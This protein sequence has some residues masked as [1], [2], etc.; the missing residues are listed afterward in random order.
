MQ[1]AV[2]LSTD[3]VEPELRTDYWRDVTRPLF[4]TRPIAGSPQPALEGAFTTRMIGPMLVGRARF[5]AQA[6]VRDRRIVSHSGLEDFYLIQLFT[7]GTAAADCE[8]TRLSISA[9]DVYAFDMGRTFNTS[10]SAGSTL[11]V[12]LHRERLDRLAGGR[13]L[14]GTLFKSGQPLTRLLADFIVG[15]ND[16]APE[17]Q[18]TGTTLEDAAVALLAASLHHAPSDTALQDPSLAPVLRRR[19]LD[20]IDANLTRQE[21]DPAML[22]RHFRVS[23]AHLYRMFEADGGVARVI[24][25]RRLD[26]AYRM[27]VRPSPPSVTQLAHDLGFSGSGQLQRAFSARFGVTPSDIRRERRSLIVED[28]RLAGMQAYL[29]GFSAPASSPASAA[30]I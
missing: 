9:G 28:G 23:R 19:V 21:L 25:E 29:A 1:D 7:A 12:V 26:A 3:L 18:E 17:I 27:L 14:H 10:A 4:D 15:L 30:S 16:V 5:N 22:M 24:R 8:G 20:F 2:L 6:Y 13:S 11:S